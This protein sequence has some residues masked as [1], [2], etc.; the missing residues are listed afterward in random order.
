[1]IGAVLFDYGGT[2]VRSSRPWAEVKI[3]AIHAEYNVL[4]QHG[5]KLSFDE[6]RAVDDSVF[7]KYA[8]LEAKLGRDIPDILKCK[9]VVDGLF[10]ETPGGW[11]ADV[12]AEANIAFWKVTTRNFMLREDAVDSLA[13]LRS[14]GLGMGIVSNHHN[15]NSLVNHLAEIGISGYFSH[16]LVSC[17]MEFRKPDPRIF[18]RSLSQLGVSKTEAIFVG[19]ST[20]YDIEGAKRTGIR[21]IL[22]MDDAAGDT[23]LLQTDSGAD[24]VVRDLRE[25]PKI[26]PSL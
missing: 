11:R 20:E 22:V 6:Y 10:P 26:V 18:E 24:F 25:I 7:Q 12:A 2:L 16:V 3:E 8:E 4:K 23:G 14:M 13:A 15:A 19:D 17:Q 9:E 5:L 21:S 1:L